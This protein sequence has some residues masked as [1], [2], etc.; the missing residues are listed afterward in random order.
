MLL[1]IGTRTIVEKLVAY[2]VLESGENELTESAKLE[3]LLRENQATPEDPIMIVYYDPKEVPNGRR[4]IWIPIQKQVKG[5]DTKSIGPIK[6]GF[7]VMGGTDH[8]VE[9]YH[10]VL[11]KKI[12]EWGLELDTKIYSIEG[13]YQPEQFDMSYGDF[14]DEDASEHW[15][16][17]ILI[18]V[19]E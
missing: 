9:Y 6:A 12:E 16:T 4:E 11:Q 2:K 17:E 7:L 13:T 3:R 18:P 15:T 14:V 19:K 8:T 10:K 1:K 5:I